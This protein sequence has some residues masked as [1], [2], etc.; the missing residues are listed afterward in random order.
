MKRVMDD[1]SWR[2]LRLLKMPDTQLNENAVHTQLNE[3]AV[4][5]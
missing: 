3:N 5:P 2:L 1:I 4:P